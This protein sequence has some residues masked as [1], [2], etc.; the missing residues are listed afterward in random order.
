MQILLFAGKMHALMYLAWK[1][2]VKGRDWYDFEW[3]VR[4]GVQLDFAHF[5]ERAYEFGSEPRGSLTPD[6]FLCMLQ[7]KIESVNFS[8]AVEDVRPFMRNPE[9][10]DFWSTDYFLQV[11]RL[12]KLQ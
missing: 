2:R 3:Y 9:H 6:S 7:R 5:C 12:M 4:K 10:T 8:A 1:N 11:A